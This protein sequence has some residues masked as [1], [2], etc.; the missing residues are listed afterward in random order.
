MNELGATLS[1]S[2]STTSSEVMQ[3]SIASSRTST[4]SSGVS[5]WVAR[6]QNESAYG[7]SEYPRASSVGPSGMVSIGS[8]IAVARTRTS[9]D[10]TRG[11]TTPESADMYPA[12]TSPESTAF[13]VPPLPSNGTGS[14]PNCVEAISAFA[15][16]PGTL[17]VPGTPS[18]TVPDSA[19]ATKSSA[20]WNGDSAGTTRTIGAVPIMP[21]GRK[22]SASNPTSPS[23]MGGKTAL[24]AVVETK[25]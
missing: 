21:S 19:A 3:V 4:T 14:I 9:P 20:V 2:P 15:E 13:M 1:P 16:M 10:S 6:N 18:M 8:V 7:R 11:S 17:V 23:R 25:V 5:G 22:L 24:A 12:W